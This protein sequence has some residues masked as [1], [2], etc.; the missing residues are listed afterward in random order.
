MAYKNHFVKIFSFII[1]A[2]S[3]LSC[4]NNGYL[5]IPFT[6]YVAPFDNGEEIIG[7]GYYKPKQYDAI[8]YKNDKNQDETI[9]DFNDVY[10]D[11]NKTINMNSTG[12]QKLL[13]IPVDF[14]DYACSLVSG[15]CNNSLINIEN[16]F[17]GDA[18]KNK[19]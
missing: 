16:A 12:Q 9:L 18:N 19:W 6:S 14:S 8:T 7:N 3:L 4:S 11:K 10:R 13:V 5:F 2:S 17:F 1:L 15:G